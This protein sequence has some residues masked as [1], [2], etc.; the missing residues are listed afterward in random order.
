MFKISENHLIKKNIWIF[1]CQKGFVILICTISSIYIYASM[2][3]VYVRKYKWKCEFQNVQGQWTSAS[4]HVIVQ[5]FV[6]NAFIWQHL[7]QFD[8]FSFVKVEEGQDLFL[9]R[10]SGFIYQ[11]FFYGYILKTQTIEY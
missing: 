8:Y 9:V 3:M 10:G 7:D 4:H 6:I 1:K 5:S 11:F 2:F